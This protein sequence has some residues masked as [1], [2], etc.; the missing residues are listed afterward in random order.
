MEASKRPDG[1][2]VE[3]V[4]EGGGGEDI[5]GKS[6]MVVVRF[7]ALLHQPLSIIQRLV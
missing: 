6:M 1:E 7:N 5:V 3:E 4:E 2:G